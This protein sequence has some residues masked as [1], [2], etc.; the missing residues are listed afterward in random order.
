VAFTASIGQ[1]RNGGLAQLR[2]H[3]YGSVQLSPVLNGLTVKDL[4]V[5]VDSVL[6]EAAAEPALVRSA[7][8][9]S[10]KVRWVD[11]DSLD[12]HVY[13]D[14]NLDWGA[15]AQPCRYH[16]RFSDIEFPLR[17]DTIQVNDALIR[18]SELATTWCSSSSSYTFWRMA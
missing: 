12:L 3:S 14:I 9:G 1:P 5:P 10:V 17:V 6:A 15:K 11:V 13:S 18:Y 8:L 7:E 4:F 16:M 2:I